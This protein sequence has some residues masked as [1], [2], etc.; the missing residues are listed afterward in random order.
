M[1]FF[2]NTISISCR[3]EEVTSMK[4]SAMLL[5]MLLLMSAPVSGEQK[6][7]FWDKLQT[8]LEKITPTKKVSTTSA[9]GGVRGAKNDDASDIYWKGRDK[10]LEMS[11]EELEKFNIAMESR[12]KG[13]NELSLKQFEEFLNL[14]PQSQFRVEGLQAAEVLR[15]EIAAA[16]AGG[17]TEA[18]PKPGESGGTPAVQE[19]APIPEADKPASEAQ[20]AK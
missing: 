1:T 6:E 5:G 20:P 17:K 18:A 14:Y 4:K 3:D 16:K 2:S 15:S 8:K 11:D 10:T 7:G 19:P 13:D 12:R 9:V